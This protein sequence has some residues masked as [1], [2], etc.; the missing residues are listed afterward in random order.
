MKDLEIIHS[1][2]FEQGEFYKY[3]KKIDF[4]IKIKGNDHLQNN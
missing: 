4:F 3:L 1:N 2:I